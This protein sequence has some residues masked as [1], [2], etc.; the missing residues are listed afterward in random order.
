[1]TG[2]SACSTARTARRISSRDDDI[3][4]VLRRGLGG[5]LQLQPHR[6]AADRPE[7]RTGRAPMAARRG[8]IRRT[9]TTTPTPSARSI[10]PATCR[11]SSGPTAR[12]SAASSVRRPS[13][14]AELWKIGQLRPGDTVR[15]APVARRGRAALAQQTRRSSRSRQHRRP[16]RRA[17]VAST[18][19]SSVRAMPARIGRASR[20][21]ARGD[22]NL[23][24]EYG[25]LVLDLALRF[26]VHALMQA[27]ERAVAQQLPGII[28]L[29]PGIRSLQIHYDAA[30]LPL[31]RS[32]RRR[33]SASRARCRR[34]I[35]MRGPSAHRAPAAVVGRPAAELA[36]STSTCSRCAPTRPGAR[37]TSSSS[38]ASTASDIGRRRQAHR[39]RRQLSRARPGRRLSR[40]AGGD[41]ARSAPSAGHHQVQSG[42]HL[43]AGERRRHRRRLS[44]R[45]RHGRAGRLPVRS[46]APAR[47]GIRYRATRCFAHGKPWLLRFFDQIRFYP[48]QRRGADRG[49]R[50]VSRRHIRS[51]RDSSSPVPGERLQAFLA[52]NARAS[53]RSRHGS[54]R[55]SRPS[56]SAGER[57]HPRPLAQ[58]ATRCTISRPTR[59]CRTARR[60]SKARCPA[61]S[62]RSRSRRAI[63]SAKARR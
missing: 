2:R 17:D 62:G 55:P 12:A 43:D 45:L 28:D 1:M 27:L 18:L 39:L 57:R 51:D 19:A 59:R 23:L 37:A 61:A 53:L 24:V 16:Q 42:A 54:R 31:E 3:D 20:I 30:A 38:A 48:G 33:S 47:C 56:A 13:S 14:Q 8:C 10:S 50:R 15:F 36:P 32:A 21:G 25:P 5:A 29:T 52:G 35:D 22:D 11:S 60:R 46:A 63:T 40:R 58:P 41:A 7:A 9:S 49:S 34:S 26:R 44:V 6:R 4:D